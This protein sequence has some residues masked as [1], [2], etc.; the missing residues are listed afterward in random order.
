M[1]CGCIGMGCGQGAGIVTVPCQDLHAAFQRRDEKIRRNTM[2]SRQEGAPSNVHA[3]MCRTGSSFTSKHTAH[4][5]TLNAGAAHR[6]HAT[7]THYKPVCRNHLRGKCNCVG[8]ASRAG[9]DT[10]EVSRQ[11]I[12]RAVGAPQR[13]R[14]YCCCSV[15][16]Q[17]AGCWW[18]SRRARGGG[19]PRADTRARSRREGAHIAAR[20]ERAVVGRRA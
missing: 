20:S 4:T 1:G 12:R 5:R 16:V 19:R 6:T 17:H 8:V 18:R 11:T 10:R 2:R 7:R 3:R 15:A 13:A 14:R 9:A